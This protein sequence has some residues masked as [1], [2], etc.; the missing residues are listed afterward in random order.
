MAPGSYK[1]LIITVDYFIKWVEAKALI[2]ITDRNVIKFFW[3]NVV[4]RFGIPSKVVSDNDKPFT[5]NLFKSYMVFRLEY[6]SSFI[7]IA[8]PQAN[9]QVEVTN[10]TIIVQGLKTH[11]DQAKG[12]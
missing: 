9:R 4:C 6:N 2:T 5:N 7:L 3:K 1:F 12:E 11:L 10:R 8:H